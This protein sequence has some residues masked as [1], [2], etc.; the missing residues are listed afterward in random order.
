MAGVEAMSIVWVWVA[1]ELQ[2]ILLAECKS[3]EGSALM[4]LQ[5]LYSRIPV[6]RP[7]AVQIARQTANGL[8]NIRSSSD[9]NVHE[10]PN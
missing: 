2:R 7:V 3:V 9:G 8:S 5:N 10:S 1:I 4:V 6:L